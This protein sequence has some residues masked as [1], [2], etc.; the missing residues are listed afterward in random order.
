MSDEIAQTDDRQ[1]LPQ[2]GSAK[3]AGGRPTLALEARRSER[4]SFGVTKR[5]K[6]AFLVA[7]AEAGLSSNDF[8][9]E[10]LCRDGARAGLGACHRAKGAPV[11][12]LVDALSR[13][14]ADLSRLH[15][16]ADETGVVPEGLDSVVARLDGKLDHLIVAAGVAAE[17]EH[18]R[19]RLETI[20]TQLEARGAMTDRA[21]GMIARFDAVVA[22]VL[23]T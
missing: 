3:R 1:R 13:I 8:A 22:K 23:S 10:V 2:C 5:Q 7:A 9:R 20:A 18:Y 15:F 11:F 19:A 12:E 6:A 4:I 17:L 16:I 21:R 14:G